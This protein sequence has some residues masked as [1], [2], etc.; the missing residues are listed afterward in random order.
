VKRH[1]EELDCILIGLE[2]VQLLETRMSDE[3]YPEELITRRETAVLQTSDTV[4]RTFYIWHQED[5]I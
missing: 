4:F 1:A 2:N 5:S 3:G